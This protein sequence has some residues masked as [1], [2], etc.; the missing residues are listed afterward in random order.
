M[1]TMNLLEE[2]KRTSFISSTCDLLVENYSQSEMD[3]A[4]KAKEEKV[5][6]LILLAEKVCILM[7]NYSSATNKTATCTDRESSHG[8]KRAV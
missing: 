2:S 7:I 6:Q 1:S 5:E 4:S 8:T 3:E